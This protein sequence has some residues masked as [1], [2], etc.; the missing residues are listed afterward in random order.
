MMAVQIL[1][2]QGGGGEGAHDQWDSK[3]V[4][5]LDRELG[6]KYSIRYPRMP[7]EDDPSYTAWKPA[8]VEELSSLKDGAILMGHSLG[9]A[10]LVHVLAEKPLSFRP[11]ALV[12]IAAPFIGEGGWPSDEIPAQANLAERLPAG[13]AVSLYLGTADDTVSVKH[14]QL[15]SRAIPQAV[16]HMLPDRNHQLN[17]D[18][19]EV[20]HDVRSLGA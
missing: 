4:A 7:H 19:T 10:F 11:L 13:L 18:L 9:G 1:F 5:S 15:Y 16:V 6:A 17:N 12:L 20:A 2:V 8:L 3:L 14:A